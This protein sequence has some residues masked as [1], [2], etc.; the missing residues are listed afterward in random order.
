MDAKEFLENKGIN[1]NKLL[2]PFRMLLPI[3]YLKEEYHNWGT[4]KEKHGKKDLPL[5]EYPYTIEYE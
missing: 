4:G 1:G 2:V 3:K 5:N